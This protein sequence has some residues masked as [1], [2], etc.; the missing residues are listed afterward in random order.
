MSIGPVEA[1]MYQRQHIKHECVTESRSKLGISSS[2]KSLRK[3][4]R[5]GKLHTKR[6][7][8]VRCCTGFA[9]PFIELSPQR[10]LLSA[11]RLAAE[12]GDK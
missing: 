1:V 10:N 3:G 12:G 8:S 2:R 7:P 4:C 6:F 9:S 11:Q 5:L